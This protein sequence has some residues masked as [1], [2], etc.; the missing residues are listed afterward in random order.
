VLS[1]PFVDLGETVLHGSRQAFG[2]W[3]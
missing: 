3:L 1:P 2:R